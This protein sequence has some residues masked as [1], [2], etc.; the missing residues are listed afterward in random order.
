MVPNPEN[1]ETDGFQ[2]SVEQS[3][4]SIPTQFQMRRM[5]KAFEAA[6][7]AVENMNIKEQN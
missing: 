4:L 7:D 2:E 1:D 5:S 6:L 3:P